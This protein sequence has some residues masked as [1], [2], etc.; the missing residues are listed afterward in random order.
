MRAVHPLEQLGWTGEWR[1]PGH[2]SSSRAHNTK[3]II[4][5]IQEARWP[6]RRGSPQSLSK[7]AQDLPGVPVLFAISQQAW[8]LAG[9]ICSTQEELMRA[10]GPSSIFLSSS[11]LL[12]P[13][14]GQRS[15][16]RPRRDKMADFPRRWLVLLCFVI[17]R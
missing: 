3:L 14:A 12:Y 6:W 4:A 8:E 17:I 7:L 11:C 9:R 5:L 1:P 13:S 15:V 10:N 2:V 16:P